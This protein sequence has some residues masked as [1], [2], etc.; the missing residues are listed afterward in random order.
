VNQTNNTDISTKEFQK[1]DWTEISQSALDGAV[2]QAKK[3]TATKAVAKP[4]PATTKQ[5]PEP[6]T[7]KTKKEIRK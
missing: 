3:T 5:K 6:K 1:D 2:K 4:K 7:K